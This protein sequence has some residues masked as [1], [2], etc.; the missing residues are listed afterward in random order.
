MTTSEAFKNWREAP[1]A[2]VDVETTGLDP[3]VDRVI[4]IGIVHMANGE[5]IDTYSSLVNP[6]RNLPEE[7]ERITG[8]KAEDI[9]DA[10]K[11]AEVAATV[12]EK[13]QGRVFVAYNLAFDRAFVRGELE[14]CGIA[15]HDP[16]YIDPLI[17]VREL[18]KT[19]GSKR[20]GAVAARLG[21]SLE[22]AHRASDDAIAAGQVLYA[23]GAQLPADL[24]DL[25][26]LQS[27]W[28]A[29]HDNEMAAWRNKKGNRFEGVGGFD[30]SN[31]GNALGPAYVY[32][33]DTDPIRAMFTH[34][35]DSGSRR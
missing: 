25:L 15:W 21:I 35:P 16:Q 29:K 6:E 27:Q 19:Q 31:R 10:P 26:M 18:H 3:D 20:L 24:D 30:A 32:G 17:F 8:I 23:L 14:R 28:E 13:L 11:F 1:L 12:M 5:V 2:V 7:V 9:V 4:E 34:L 33:E 22:N